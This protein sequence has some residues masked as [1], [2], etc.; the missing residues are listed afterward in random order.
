MLVKINGRKSEVADNATIREVVMA[1]EFK[2]S[3]IVVQRNGLVTLREVWDVPLKSDDEL[4]I[5]RVI[6]GG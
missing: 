3:L 5:V 1:S 2:D 6:G 4:E